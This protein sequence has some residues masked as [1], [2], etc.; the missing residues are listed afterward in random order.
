[1]GGRCSTPAARTARSNTGAR[2][3]PASSRA[4]RAAR[5]K[6]KRPSSGG[7]PAQQQL[8]RQGFDGGSQLLQFFPQLPFLNIPG[9]RSGPPAVDFRDFVSYLATERIPLPSACAEVSYPS[10]RDTL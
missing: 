10:V 5:R 4:S 7:G 8:F 1:M 6:R 2:K 9:V 3:A